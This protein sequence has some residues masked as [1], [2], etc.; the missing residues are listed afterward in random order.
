MYV[1]RDLLWG[2]AKVEGAHLY[3]C[4]LLQYTTRIILVIIMDRRPDIGLNIEQKWERT[5]ESPTELLF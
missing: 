1:C 3:P 5:I 2:I 4:I